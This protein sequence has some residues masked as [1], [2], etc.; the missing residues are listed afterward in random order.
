[1]TKI[2]SFQETRS[3]VEWADQ[4]FRPVFFTMKLLQTRGHG[5][6][7]TFLRALGSGREQGGRMW[8]MRY[9]AKTDSCGLWALSFDGDGNARQIGTR[10]DF[11][12][13]G[14][15]PAA[16]ARSLCRV[17][18]NDVFHGTTTIA[19]ASMFPTLNW[20]RCLD[21]H[22]HIVDDTGHAKI[23][24]DLPAWQRHPRWPTT[25]PQRPAEARSSNPTQTSNGGV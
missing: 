22:M 15:F 3:D 8:G 7:L 24:D 4:I 13:L 11:E 19:F 10:P 9:T 5:S 18:A 2:K 25:A 20:K 21:D 1:M 14:F 16:D 12:G 23:L 17:L 6:K